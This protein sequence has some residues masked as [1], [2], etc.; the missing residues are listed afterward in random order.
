M[1]GSAPKRGLYMFTIVPPAS[2]TPSIRAIQERI[3]E[4][5]HSHEALRRPVH[6]TLIPPFE[7]TIVTEIQLITFLRS[8]AAARPSFELQLDGFGQFREQVIYIKPIENPEL[9]NLQ[10]A[11]VMSFG[12][13][14]QDVR[15]R[16]SHDSFHPH[17]TLAY[18]DLTHPMF[19]KA[20]ENV[21]RTTFNASFEVDRITLM[22]HDAEWVKI[23]Q[24]LLD[25]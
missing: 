6:L 1:S 8:F 10:H 12:A 22:R 25:A 21:N 17:F 24:G 2:I 18:R 23:A 13:T 15:S 7:T 9:S 5:Y 3:A 20:W 14:F 16:T 11:L 4:E 19:L